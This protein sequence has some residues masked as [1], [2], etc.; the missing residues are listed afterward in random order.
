MPRRSCHCAR[1]RLSDARR[2]DASVRASGARVS[3]TT[4]RSCPQMALEAALLQFVTLQDVG[5]GIPPSATA[6]AILQTAELLANETM[7]RMHDRPQLHED[8]YAA[9]HAKRRQER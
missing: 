7:F 1:V 5:I 2:S 3:L 9:R 4:P 8:L 6:A